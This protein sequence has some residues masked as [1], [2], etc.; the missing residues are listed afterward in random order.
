MEKINRSLRIDYRYFV[1]S[2]RLFSRADLLGSLSCV[3][4]VDETPVNSIVQKEF[5]IIQSG[6]DK[7]QNLADVVRII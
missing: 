3:F 4:P 2:Y 6:A 1:I 7:L 5:L